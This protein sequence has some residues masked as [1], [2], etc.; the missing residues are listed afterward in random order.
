ME[1]VIKKYLGDIKT[2][3]MQS[4]KNLAM[5]PLL[6]SNNAMA[7]YLMLDEALKENLVEIVELD[8]DG[9]VP[10]L[11]VNNKGERMVLLIDGE[12]VVGAKQNR[13]INTTIL[14]AAHS[15]T[16]I[17]VS[18]VEQGRWSYDSR[19]FSSHER[20]MSPDM[21]SKKAEQ[22]NFSVRETGRFRSNQGAIWEEI[23][24][25]A[26]RMNAES[27]SMAMAEIY[28][29]QAESL[30]DYS[31]KFSLISEQTGALFM[32]NGKVA[33]LDSFGKPDT[34]SKVFKKLIESY[35]LD[36]I[37][38]YDP[39]NNAKPLKSKANIFMDGVN[40]A[41][42]EIHDSV[43]LGKDIRL[44][45]ETVT[46]FAL[47][48]NSELLHLCAFIKENKAGNSNC[49]SRIERFSGRRRNRS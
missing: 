26:G 16:V 5:F 47:T 14:I 34:F 9:S 33:G 8:H 17:P 38:W 13:I 15:S 37:D 19:K 22:V 27:P 25:K 40:S 30:E 12:E 43:A 42:M 23:D 35:A 24:S 41:L 32:I 2:G 3:S 48:H 36:A 7:D 28:E 46:G 45:S 31:K 11:E 6:S 44:D 20:F 18:C 49:N 39:A 4:Y 21:R 29:K 1:E 10:D